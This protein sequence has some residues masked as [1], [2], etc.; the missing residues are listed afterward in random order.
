VPSF[1]RSDFVEAEAEEEELEEIKSLLEM[2][3]SSPI[4]WL[5]YKMCLLTDNS[6]DPTDSA[7]PFAAGMKAA[8]SC[9]ME[10]VC[11]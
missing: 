5:E 8:F 9:A 11:V 6:F 1:F 10:K 2:G 7:R 4:D 3:V